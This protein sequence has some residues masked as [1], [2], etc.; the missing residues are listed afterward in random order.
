MQRSTVALFVRKKVL[1]CVVLV[2]IFGLGAV[3][4]WSN[5][6]V[7]PMLG[8]LAS[9]H[10]VL[11]AGHGGIDPGTH[12]QGGVLEKDITLDVVLRLGDYL[13]L[14]GVP[15]EFT[16]E[17]DRDVTGSETI[18]RGRHRRDLEGRLRIFNR[19]IVA[20][21]VHVNS[22]RDAAER[23]TVVFYSVILS[24]ASGWPEKSC[25]RSAECRL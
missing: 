1:L 16:R 17:T 23:G 24:L 20:V 8:G 25:K 5:Y 18:G 19:G 12:D 2:G 9:G 10:V 22:S 4:V 21:S 7:V 6:P 14:Q 13:T 11:D 3:A 15:V